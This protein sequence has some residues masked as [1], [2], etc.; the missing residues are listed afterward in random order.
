MSA[1]V[2]VVVYSLCWAG[3]GLLSGWAA[4]RIPLERLRADGP[5]TRIR[6]WE[7]GGRVYDRRLRVRVWKDRLPEAGGL[8]AGGWAKDRIRSF[9]VDDLERF[10]AETRRA[11][12]VH[13]ANV[14]FGATFALWNDAAVA[15]VMVVFGAAVHL[16]FVVVQRYN[17]AR[18]V[19]VI[20]LA[21]R[22]AERNAANSS[23]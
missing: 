10:A 12:R 6:R 11:E 5:V 9:T 20:S 23:P 16:P 13:W 17:R 7:D 8:F 22:R 18:L 15:V 2:A 21:R 4:H 19:H 1:P 3:F 14:V